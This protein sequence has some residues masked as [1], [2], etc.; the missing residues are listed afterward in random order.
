MLRAHVVDGVSVTDASRLHGYSRAEFYLV[1]DAFSEAGMVGLLEKK[2][3][4][5]GPL[6]VTRRSVGS[7]RDSARSPGPRRRHTSRNASA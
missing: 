4:R 7:S 3:G 1:A 5:K 2:R 6:K